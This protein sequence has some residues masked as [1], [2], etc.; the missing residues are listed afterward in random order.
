MSVWASHQPPF[1]SLPP[2]PGLQ[3]SSHYF[4][5]KLQYLS[6]LILPVSWLPCPPGTSSRSLIGALQKVPY[7]TFEDTKKD[8]RKVLPVEIVSAL[9][10]INSNSAAQLKTAAE[11]TTSL[12]TDNSRLNNRRYS[13]ILTATS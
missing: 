13:L 4:N 7:T 3:S 6:A 9:D 2:T 10:H 5:L 11:P 8:Q 1:A 12:P